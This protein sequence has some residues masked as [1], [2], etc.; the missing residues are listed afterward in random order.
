M[1][2]QYALD[3]TF[4]LCLDDFKL[5]T[6]ASVPKF[7][8]WPFFSYMPQTKVH[9]ELTTQEQI[10]TNDRWELFKHLSSLRV[11]WISSKVSILYFFSEFSLFLIVV[12]GLLAQPLLTL[13]FPALLY[14]SMLV[15]PVSPKQATCIAAILLV[16]LSR[17]TKAVLAITTTE[18]LIFQQQRPRLN[19]SMPPFPVDFSEFPH[20]W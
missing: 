1:P 4:S 3:P 10:S 15:F 9:W 18:C 7:S 11:R 17:G 16:S 5:P 6:T 8:S 19:Y 20:K 12:A 13:F 14:H 2:C